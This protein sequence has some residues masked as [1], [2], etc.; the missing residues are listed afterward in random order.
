[1]KDTTELERAVIGSLLNLPEHV[2]P[3]LSILSAEDFTSLERAK[4]WRAIEQRHYA[5]EAI[6]AVTVGDA[7][8][9]LVV[10]VDHAHNAPP[11]N[12]APV[13]AAQLAQHARA[14][15]ISGELRSTLAA[16]EGGNYDAAD[17]LPGVLSQ[18]QEG[19]G[20]RDAS[21]SEALSRG[22]GLVDDA[23]RTSEGG[24]IAFGLP[25][26]DE[27]LPI[28]RGRGLL[29]IVA[30][31]PS[32]GKT[33]LANQLSLKTAHQGLSVGKVELEMSIEEM[34]LRS[35][36]AEYRIN[37]SA[38]AAGDDLALEQLTTCV[39]ERNI[40]DLPIFLDDRSYSLAEVTARIS[41][42]HRKHNI[43]CVTVDHLHLISHKAESRN[44]TISEIT[45]ALKL[46]A[47]RLEMPVILLSQLARLSERENRKP[48]LSDLRDS[49]G[50]EQDADI[51]VAL[52]SD[53][54]DADENGVRWVDI[55]L[56]KN[57]GGRTGWIP[58]S[59]AFDGRYQTFAEHALRLPG[60]AQASAGAARSGHAR[61]SR[62]YGAGAAA[63]TGRA[64]GDFQ[65]APGLP[66][67]TWHKDWD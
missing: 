28:L 47:K 31:R 11:A 64:E 26:L 35:I 34:A 33:A 51:V 19:H 59:Y 9:L 13:Y 25:A 57:R 53:G 56:L 4:I 38:L 20:R 12:N 1:L 18:L 49:G 27:R 17:D 42:W 67:G 10:C 60:E 29:V 5:G 2:E 63:V 8:N 37:G 65:R 44:Q 36:A 24:Q 15:K 3:C 62:T 39:Q 22:L 6:D 50:I 46:L 43:A 48:K 54:L 14:R 55:G 41:E 23:R 32:V 16:I 52:H 45:R 40:R 30:A 66:P 21:F 58:R 7:T 61:A